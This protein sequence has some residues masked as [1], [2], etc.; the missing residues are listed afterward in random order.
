L[1]EEALEG[2]LS[3]EELLI[4]R[5]NVLENVIAAVPRQTA[6]YRFEQDL[7]KLFREK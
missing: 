7:H 4:Y 1:L 6:E 3:D 2:T 5:L